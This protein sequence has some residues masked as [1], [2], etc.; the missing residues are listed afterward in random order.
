MIIT[1]II[2]IINYTENTIYLR[3]ICKRLYDSQKKQIRKTYKYS[4]SLS[5]YF[6]GL[7]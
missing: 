5:S 3:K 1:N 7:I 4:S 6:A 2:R